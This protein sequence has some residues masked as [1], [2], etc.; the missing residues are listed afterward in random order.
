[1]NPSSAHCLGGWGVRNVG[2]LLL[3]HS[4]G[5]G[6]RSCTDPGGGGGGGV[7]NLGT[8]TLTRCTFVNNIGLDIDGGAIENQGTMTSDQC[9][10]ADNIALD[11]RGGGI[12]NSPSGALL[13][14]D[15]TLTGNVAAGAGGGIWNGGALVVINSTLG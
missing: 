11:D 9:T 15:S 10:F 4:V 12:F 14:T 8:A 2:T 5:R 3:T 1:A 7:Q 6:K 13:L